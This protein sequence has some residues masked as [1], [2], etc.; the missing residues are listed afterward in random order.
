MSPTAP[1]AARPAARERG[2]LLLAAA[3]G[4]VLAL[5]AGAPTWVRGTTATTTGTSDV[6]A[7]GRDAAGVATAL[8]L[9]SLAAVVATTIGR[10]VARTVA[11]LVLVLGG[12]GVVVGSLAVVTD[13]AA[14]LSAPAR[15]A[16]GQTSAPVDD[17]DLTPWP[18]VS[19]V[20]GVLTAVA[21]VGVLLRGR[22]WTASTRYERDAAGETGPASTAPAPSPAQDPAAAWDSLTHGDDPTR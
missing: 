9:V 10:R 22:R 2:T 8:A 6:L 3:A 13:P 12:L 17:V 18:V 21:G 11:A 14:A 19:A 7:G 16:S 15:A 4:A 1:A 5:A 20:G